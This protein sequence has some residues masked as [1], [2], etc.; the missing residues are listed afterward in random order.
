MEKALLHP[1]ADELDDWNDY[2]RVKGKYTGSEVVSMLF[3]DSELDKTKS[4]D[5]G[6]LSRSR[7]GSK[8]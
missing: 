7:Q 4:P 2:L 1:T 5:S 6:Y 3:G 8:Q